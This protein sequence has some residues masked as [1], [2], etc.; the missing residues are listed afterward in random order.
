M[1]VITMEPPYHGQVLEYSPWGPMV[2]KSAVG[3]CMHLHVSSVG[4]L[5]DVRLHHPCSLSSPAPDLKCC[6]QPDDNV[7]ATVPYHV[8][9]FFLKSHIHS[10]LSA[11]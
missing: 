3:D 1:G 4:G 9:V 11:L 6:G 8:D 5:L 2:S 7:P 10:Q